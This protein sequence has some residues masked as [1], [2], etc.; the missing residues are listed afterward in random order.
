MTVVISEGR[1]TDVRSGQVDPIPPG[2]TVIDGNGKYLIPGLWD[3]HIHT[4]SDAI[5]REILYP[6][7]L[8]NGVTGVR[9]M[10]ADCFE[11][12]ANACGTLQSSVMDAH[13]R[14]RDVETGTL[15]GP[16]E[17]VSSAFADGPWV[18]G[19]S[20]VQAP[21]TAEDA[22]AFVR[23]EWQRGVDFI[24]VYDMLPREAYFAVVDE[25]R[26][27]GIPIA[28][29]V[30]VAVK[31]SE[32]SDAGQR[33]IEHC[34]A[35]SI[36]EECS[37]REEEL[38]PAVLAELGSEGPAVLPLMRQMVESY[39]ADKC[40]SLFQRFIQNDTWFTPTLVVELGNE[41][42]RDDS[43]LRYVPAEE[44][45]FFAVMEEAGD[46]LYE[47]DSDAPYTNW[48][49]SMTLELHESGVGLLAGSD[50]G[51]PGAIWGFSL[52]DELEL[53]VSVGLSE[54]SVLR[55]ATYNPAVFLG[56]ADS[57][58]TI[59]VGKKADLVLLDADP[60]ENIRNTRRIEA[61]IVRGKVLDRDAIDDL[62]AHVELAAKD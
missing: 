60:L 54:T 58:G 23:L 62:L 39:D 18:D 1:I 41:S 22:R 7:F 11:E 45:A 27:L 35:G 55:M 25:G 3:M 57:L 21:G 49:R 13:S 15:L 14:R 5:T 24:K 28:G 36:L 2:A 52:H 33:S 53:L 26:N 8:A 56:A 19:T 34:C 42:L 61:V 20:T 40:A 38:R 46:E 48:V 9:N 12:G 17:V 43:I 6:L 31:A 32:A 50:A 30:P 44:K 51:D 47:G 10:H 59:D 29:H 16:H 4:S 37:A